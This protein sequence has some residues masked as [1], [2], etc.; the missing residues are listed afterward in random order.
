MKNTAATVTVGKVSIETYTWDKPGRY[1]AF[2]VQ[3]GWKGSLYPYTMQD[4]LLHKRKMVKYDQITLENDYIRVTVLPGLGGHLWSAYDKVSGKEMFYNNQV[5][6]VGLVALRG[7]WWASGIEWNFP[8]GHSVSTVSPVDFTTSRNADGSVTAVVGDVDR[9]TRMRWTV[10]ITVHPGR[11]GFSL[12]TVLSNPAAYPHRYMYW[13]NCAIHTTDGFQFISPAKSAWT[14][15]GQKPFPV[16]RGV[17]QSWYKEQQRA[18]DFFTLGVGQDY[19]GYYDHER[20]FGAVHIA[21]NRKMP[22]KKFFTWGTADHAKMWEKSLTDTD[23]PYIELQCGL[24]Y[25]QAM[26]D[27]F[28]PLAAK[29]WD[30]V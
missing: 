16:Y 28:D 14:W 21:D 30:E 2:L 1:P 27:F 10:K 3:P 13:E 8:K 11:T 22:G 25:T 5:V 18:V 29:A 6:K 17:D 4:R 23:G 19:F 15:G 7:A 9:I 20:L 24:S 12:E 26:Y